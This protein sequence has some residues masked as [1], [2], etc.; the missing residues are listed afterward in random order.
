MNASK[1]S[2]LTVRSV[3][4]VLIVKLDVEQFS[5]ISSSGSMVED[6][7]T[8]D[9]SNPDRDRAGRHQVGLGHL[10]PATNSSVCVWYISNPM[11]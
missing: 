4:C 7:P 3:H 9:S 5:G 6:V 11:C 10:Q 2:K 1:G 8:A